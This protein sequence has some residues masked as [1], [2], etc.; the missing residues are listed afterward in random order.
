MKSLKS[1]VLIPLTALAIGVSGCNLFQNP[2]PKEIEPNTTS[3]TGRDNFNVR[4]NLG[5]YNVGD[6]FNYEVC[7]Q[8]KTEGDIFF[9]NSNRDSFKYKLFKDGNEITNKKI[10]DD[11][12]M[13]MHKDGYIQMKHEGNKMKLTLRGIGIDIYGGH[14][15]A[16]L[17]PLSGTEGW[18]NFNIVETNYIITN[19][20]KYW[21]KAELIYTKDNQ[22]YTDT[23][24]SQE[25][26]VGAK[27]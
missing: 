7:I 23:F 11:F 5:D 18:Y 6:E 19:S 25:F 15:E 12:L 8:N 4:I 1:L 24:A 26:N 13:N 22:C 16:P 14:H 21:M 27:E 20:G 10:R 3:E 2:E 9:N 17:N